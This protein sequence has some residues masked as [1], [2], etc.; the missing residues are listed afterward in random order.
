MTKK[1]LSC[2]IMLLLLSLSLTLSA[3]NLLDKDKGNSSGMTLPSM[4]VEGDGV[5]LERDEKGFS[6]VDRQYLAYAKEKWRM[7]QSASDRFGQ[8]KDGFLDRIHNKAAIILKDEVYVSTRNDLLNA[9]N[10]IEYADPDKVPAPMKNLYSQMLVASNR[11]RRLIYQV[12][13]VNGIDIEENYASYRQTL[14]SVNE[15]VQAFFAKADS[16]GLEAAAASM[17]APDW[18]ALAEDRAVDNVKSFNIGDYGLN[19]GVSRWAV[20]GVEGLQENA[21]S[22]ETLSYP[23]HIYQYDCTRTYHFNEQGQLDS[24]HYSIDGASFDRGNYDDPVYDDMYELSAIVMYAFI[25]EGPAI[26]SQPIDTG[27]GHW[28]VTF[29]PAAESVVLSAVQN[30]PQQNIQLDVYAKRA[31]AEEQP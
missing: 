20:M 9:V 11:A 26:R 6:E 22:M 3:C 19:W 5:S 27:D 12:L 13:S 2:T 29:D 21:M 10:A 24:Y 31:A 30:D 18:A 7:L 1:T 4:V 16:E 25:L 15:S 23:C 28:Q 14:D 8:E 17:P